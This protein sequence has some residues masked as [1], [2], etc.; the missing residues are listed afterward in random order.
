MAATSLLRPSVSKYQDPTQFLKDWF[1]YLKATDRN[2]SLRALARQSG[3]SVSYLTMMTQK[4][5]PLTN[6]LFSKIAPYLKLEPAEMRTLDRLVDLALSKTTEEKKAALQK[7]QNLRSYREVNPAEWEVHKYLSKWFNL[8]I[9]EMVQLKNFKNDPSWIQE[10]L[11]EKVSHGE[12]TQALELLIQLG[13]I[14]QDDGKLRIQKRTL[15][16]H[17]E[18]FRISLGSFHHEMLNLA[19]KSIASTPRD[20]RVVL[21]STIGMPKEKVGEL[22]EMVREFQKKLEQWAEPFK[23][24]DEIYHFEAAAFPL[25]KKVGSDR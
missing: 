7:L 25:T 19:A 1:L 22:L 4:T 2:F 8:A 6:T 20:Q 18:I 9:R 16:C 23:E 24:I 10:R 11:L 13:L 12:I 14:D 21:G 17:D 5:R 3:I 15:Q